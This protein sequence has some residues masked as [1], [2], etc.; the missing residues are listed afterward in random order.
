[1]KTCAAVALKP[2]YIY[3]NIHHHHILLI[4]IPPALFDFAISRKCYQYS[5]SHFE[6]LIFI[7]KRVQCFIIMHDVWRYED[8][9]LRVKIR[10]SVVSWHRLTTF[11]Q[12]E[13]FHITSLTPLFLWDCSCSWSSYRQCCCRWWRVSNSYFM[14]SFII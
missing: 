8:I 5:R 12:D 13:V 6:S 10:L 1:M 14:S 7:F 3:R 11:D 9:R 2:S 4:F